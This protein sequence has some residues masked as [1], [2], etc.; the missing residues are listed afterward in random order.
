[1][2]RVDWA[3]ACRFAEVN[4]NLATIV[5]G[6]IDHTL[7]PALPAPVQVI[8]LARL[9]GPPEE[10]QGEHTVACA[11]Y[12]PNLSELARVEGRLVIPAIPPADWVLAIYYP[13]AV[14][15]LASDAGAYRLEV[16]I[17]NSEAYPIP[18]HVTDQ[19]PPG[20]PQ[21]PSPEA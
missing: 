3:I 19:P 15:F 12:A 9:V 17:D 13:M 4:N 14:Q 6:G 8:V 18:M 2:L 11:A 21:P 5:G 10:F 16:S 7:V 20:M 1:M